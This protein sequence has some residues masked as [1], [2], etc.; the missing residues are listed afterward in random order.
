MSKLSTISLF[1]IGIVA[2]A[3]CTQPVNNS[4]I[5]KWKK[6]S[7]Y[8]TVNDNGTQRGEY[9]IPGDPTHTQYDVTGNYTITGNTFTFVNLAGASSCPMGDTGVYTFTVNNNTLN[10]VLISDQCSGRGMYTPGD[11]T[12]Q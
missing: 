11:Y 6:D 4:I 10:L 9:Q 7:Q 5:G 2:L 1:I 12:R 3:S 8:L